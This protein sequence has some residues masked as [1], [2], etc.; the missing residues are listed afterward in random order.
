M[1]LDAMFRKVRRELEEIPSAP[2]NRALEIRIIE[3][4]RMVSDLGNHLAM[5]EDRTQIIRFTDRLP[6]TGW[7]E[8]IRHDVADVVSGLLDHL[9]LDVALTQ[10]QVAKTVL[11][12]K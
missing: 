2:S 10:P 4:E 6:H 12:K 8:T 3:L 11:V 5:L 7:T 9:G 1:S